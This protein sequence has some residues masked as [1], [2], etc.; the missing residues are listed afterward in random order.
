M[1]HRLTEFLAQSELP[2]FLGLSVLLCADCLKVCCCYH[3]FVSHMCVLFDAHLCIK[4]S[5]VLS[6][7][8]PT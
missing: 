5:D 7:H 8:G 2:V 4:V 1:F 6:V 3:T